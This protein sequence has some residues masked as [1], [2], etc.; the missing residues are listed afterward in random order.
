MFSHEKDHFK[1]SPKV[2]NWI[3]PFMENKDTTV[4]KLMV[5]FQKGHAN[6]NEKNK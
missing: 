5:T 1:N 4:V 6:N 2:F 3:M